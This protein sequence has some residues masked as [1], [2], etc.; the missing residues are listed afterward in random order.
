MQA[1][2]KYIR[3]YTA[4]ILLLAA[5]ACHRKTVPAGNDEL[6]SG[7]RHTETGNASYYADKFIGR[8]TASGEKYNANAYTA[9]HRKLAFGTKVKVTNVANGKSVVVR[10]ND[11]GPFVSGRIIDVSKAAAQKLGLIAAGVAK[12]KIEYVD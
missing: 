5:A 6:G 3:L 2:M 10:I 12:V 11:R 4:F 1:T 7:K 8:P 9:A